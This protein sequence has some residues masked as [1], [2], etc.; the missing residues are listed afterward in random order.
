VNTHKV[1]LRILMYAH[2]FIMH[3]WWIDPDLFGIF[4]EYTQIYFAYLLNTHRFIWHIWWE[5]HFA[6]LVNTDRF[7]LQVWLM[8]T[9]SFGILGEI[10]Q[11]HFACR[12]EC[13]QFH[14][15]DSKQW[16]SNKIRAREI[17]KFF[18]SR[19]LETLKEHFERWSMGS[20]VETKLHFA[21]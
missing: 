7:I 1:I 12:G 2:R 6:F 10:T 17:K 20:S 8:H 9:D 18:V 11:I 13:A 5:I 3:T 21:Y 15:T 19:L 4:G 16:A 14:F